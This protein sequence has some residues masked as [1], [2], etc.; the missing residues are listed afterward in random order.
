MCLLS[1]LK[2]MLFFDS[3]G[4][5]L[6]K[7]RLDKGCSAKHLA[8]VM[9]KVLKEKGKGVSFSD[10]RTIKP[11]F[12]RLP[13]S[14]TERLEYELS[15]RKPGPFYEPMLCWCRYLRYLQGMRTS[16]VRSGRMGFFKYLRHTWRIE[17]LLQAPVS[18]TCETIGRMWKAFAST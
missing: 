3:N 16:G 7:Y 8:T 4:S 18:T 14:R 9:T 12:E 1:I 11:D 6:T 2:Q 17:R 5:E 13:V 10:F 15:T